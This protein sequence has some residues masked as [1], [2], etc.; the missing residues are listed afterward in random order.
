L[1]SV[2]LYGR[3]LAAGVEIYEYNRTM[4]HHKY[5]VCDG[6]W[7]TVGTTNFDN[8]AFALNEENNVC[9]YDRAVAAEFERIF[10]A[11]LEVCDRVRLEEWRRRPLTQKICEAAVSVLKD[12]V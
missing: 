7:S 5:M 1:N 2:R 6:V 3:L 10:A 12:Q 9:I 4:L 8:R 11:D